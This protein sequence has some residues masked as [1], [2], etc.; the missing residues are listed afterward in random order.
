MGVFTVI[1]HWSLVIGSGTL[2]CLNVLSSK[3]LL[4]SFRGI[5]F[6]P[7]TETTMKN[8]LLTL[9]T[10]LIAG[11]MNAQELTK[12]I[13]NGNLARVDSILKQDP[14]LLNRADEDGITPLFT[15]IEAKQPEIS[16]YLIER[17]ANVHAKTKQD[18]PLLLYAAIFGQTETARLLIEKKA[19]V[20]A[21][22]NTG[23]VPLHSAVS[24][25]RTDI[26]KML[27][28]HG[29]KIDI[30]NND[31]DTPL[32]WARNTN[33]FDAVA[34]L[35]EKGA[36]VNDRNKFNRTPLM[37]AADRG[38][39]NL[40][41][42]YLKNGADINVVDSLGMTALTLSAISRNPDG[43]S[44]FLILNGAEV[45]PPACT[46]TGSC[47]CGPPYMTPLHMAAQAGQP[48]MVRNLLSSGAK[49]NLRNENGYT[50]LMLAVKR[51]NLETVK[52]LTEKGAFL[53]VK[54]KDL[55]YTELA[56]A[57]ALGN[58]EIVNYLLAAGADPALANNEGKTPFDLACYYGHRE[59]AYTL[60]AREACDAKMKEFA[61]Q[62][63]LTE[64]SLQEKQAV[65]WF[66]GHGS[67]AVKTKNHLLV[68]D[69]FINP[70]E[71]APADSSLACGYINPEELKGMDVMVFSTHSHPDH[72]SKD[73]FKWK[74]SIPQ[75]NYVLCFNPPDNPGEYNY[76]PIHGEKTIDGVKIS[77][78]RS[79]DLDGG[80]LVEADGLTIFQPGDLA[81]GQDDLMKAFTDEVD[82]VASKTSQ[83]DILF[84]PIRG[85][86][87]GRPPQVK[88]GVEYMIS[89]LNPVV[90]FP[91]H[92]GSN[93]VEYKKFAD[94]LS[95]KRPNV[96]V[97]Y[98][99]NRG[100]HFIF[101]N[102]T[103]LSQ[104]K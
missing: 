88:L 66:L 10:L 79:T 6:L 84:A 51:G 76:I 69:Y 91:Q 75:I 89:K 94:E 11:I 45:N 87:L 33:T 28:E 37:S 72:Y 65:V 98:V 48:A 63:P 53:N 20:N 40:A 73:I 49:I 62:T 81:N 60:G 7:E 27:V 31:G 2:V 83:I 67:W 30:R 90:F 52:L 12:A 55:G 44:R 5:L 24:F 54:D 95:A 43:M 22:N 3:T 80:Y 4:I 15:A 101:E 104:L 92:S 26:V 46:H 82:L 9:I 25:G 103:A 58:K 99:I 74:K 71:P 61:L 18:W 34:Y 1:G 68:F 56:L 86:S 100:D 102:G 35:I 23:I 97:K 21:K 57:A 96:K 78:I 36:K 39:V 38:S 19:D 41:E 13:T 17:G 29:A 16:R 47:L 70:R 77:T 32:F 42:L 85:C 8:I 14:S 59:I 93:T 50:P 64:R